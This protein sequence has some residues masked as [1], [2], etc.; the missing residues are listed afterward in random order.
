MSKPR[1]E[2]AFND[3][4]V[5][6][7]RHSVINNSH[8]LTIKTFEAFVYKSYFWI[9]ENSIN[10]KTFC[11]FRNTSIFP[12]VPHGELLKRNTTKEKCKVSW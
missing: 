12:I 8:N 4:K 2:N 9:F 10:S 11:H 6:F 3:T 5:H 7:M 1:K